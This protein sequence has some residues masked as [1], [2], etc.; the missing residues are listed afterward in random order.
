MAGDRPACRIANR[1]TIARL[2]DIKLMKVY[3]V[4]FKAV[5]RVAAESEAQAAKI[6]RSAIDNEPQLIYVNNLAFLYAE[7]WSKEE[8]LI[9]P[10]SMIIEATPPAD[11]SIEDQD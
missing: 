9:R 2:S 5:M 11:I 7:A 1:R 6:A 4:E 3:E 10:G 8:E